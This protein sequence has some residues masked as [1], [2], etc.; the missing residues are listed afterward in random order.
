[1]VER[2]ALGELLKGRV[3]CTLFYEPSTRTSTSFEAAMLR[4]GGSVVSIDQTSSSIAKGESLEDTGK[5]I[6]LLSLVFPH[7][8]YILTIL[9]IFHAI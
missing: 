7:V 3:M 2:R 5:S 9:H 6:S 8:S 4:L 1:M